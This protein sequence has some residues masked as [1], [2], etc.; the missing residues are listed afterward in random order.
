MLT[1][2]KKTRLTIKGRIRLP[3][4]TKTKVVFYIWNIGLLVRDI[5]FLKCS[6][7][8]KIY[9]SILCIQLSGVQMHSDYIPAI[10]S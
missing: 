10:L 2:K 9:D 8:I 4:L 6:A 3:E 5:P 7:I 1:E